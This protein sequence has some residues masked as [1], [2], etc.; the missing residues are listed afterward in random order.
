MKPGFHLWI[1]MPKSSQSNGCTHIHQTSR[2]SLSKHCLSA[3]KM[4][5][6]I[7]CEGKGVMMVKFMQKWTPLTSELYC[8]TLE[9]LRRVIQSKRIGMLTYGVVL[10]HDNARQYTAPHT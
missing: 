5:A 1:L 7:F 9:K 2:K 10:L 6:T 8:E 3:R 4:I